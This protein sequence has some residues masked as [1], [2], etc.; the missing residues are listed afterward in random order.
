MWLVLV[1]MYLLLCGGGVLGMLAWSV[2]VLY[3]RPWATAEF[4]DAIIAMQAYWPCHLGIG[5]LNV[6]RSIGRLLDRGCMVK[7]LPLVIDGDLVAVV[8]YMIKVRGRDTVGVTKVKGHAEDVGVQQGRVRLV[9]QQ[10]NV[11]ADTAADLGRRHHSQILMNAWRM[12]LKVRNHWYP[13]MLQLLRFMIAVARVTVN[14]VGRGGTAPDPLVW[15]QGGRKKTR[16]TDI[17]DN[18]DLATSPGPP[19]FLGGPSIQVH[20][21]GIAA[22]NI[23][24][25]PYSV[26]ILCKVTAFLG[27]LHWPVDAVDMGHFGL[28]LKFLSF[29]SNG[30]ATGC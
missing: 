3:V 21:G 28:F 6:A 16:R 4:W 7:N 25:W 18:I 22:A 20:G 9:D 23:A 24:A 10:G 17:R 12:L 14:P 13:I 29:S 15:D 8:Q 30:L 27:T 26:G 5:N 19:G 2:A 1:F 11:E